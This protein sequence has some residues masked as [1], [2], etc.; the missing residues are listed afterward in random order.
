MHAVCWLVETHGLLYRCGLGWLIVKTTIESVSH[1]NA[2]L[3]ADDTALLILLCFHT[4]VDGFHEISLG[5]KQNLEHTNHPCCW[6]I[7]FT[8]RVLE[9]SVCENI[10]LGH[11][12]LGCDFNLLYG[13]F[14]TWGNRYC[15]RK[16]IYTVAK[17]QIDCIT[18]IFSESQLKHFLCF[19]YFFPRASWNALAHHPQ[20]CWQ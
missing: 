10:L 14:Y 20:H 7:K 15:W 4:P 16:G 1:L 13:M 5:P 17:G 9:I 19:I 11:A 18:N 3:V 12:L 2:V 8:K 6:N